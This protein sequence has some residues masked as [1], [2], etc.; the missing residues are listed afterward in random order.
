MPLRT[1]LRP[2]YHQFRSMLNLIHNAWLRPRF[3]Y[4]SPSARVSSKA[5]LYG[6]RGISIG[7]K[8]EIFP[9]AVLNCTY[10]HNIEARAGRIEIGEG[11]IIQ[12]FAFLH[13]HAGLIRLG[14]D[15]SVNSYA[16]LYG[17]GG[18][19]IG[20]HVRIAAH[21]VI[22]PG[23]HQFE[24]SDIPISQQGLTHKGIK[25]EDDVWIGAGVKILDGV[26]IARGCVIGAGSVVTRS[27]EPY[28]VYVGA[29]AR[30]IKNRGQDEAEN[31]S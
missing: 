20:D 30:R 29:P 8:A 26:Q 22:V 2:Y 17:E 27:T 15:C 4:L 6:T 13:T 12:P 11:T 18:L 21:T 10:W 7:P 14:K 19:E 1:A 31:P 16:V 3:A 25:I 5:I 28:G 24:R 23:N 9:H